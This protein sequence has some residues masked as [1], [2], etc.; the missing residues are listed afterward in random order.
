MNLL[1]KSRI[2]IILIIL[3]KEK[4]NMEHGHGP[5]IRRKFMNNIE[6]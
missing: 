3:W 6:I 2:H 5:S 4:K 1:E